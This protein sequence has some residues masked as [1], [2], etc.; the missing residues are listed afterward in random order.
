MARITRPVI[1][2]RIRGN[3]GSLEARVWQQWLDEAAQLV[4][5]FDVEDNDDPFAYNETASVSLLCSAAARIGCLPLAEFTV[6]KKGVKD[7]RRRSNGRA[8]FWMRET[9]RDWAFEF[10]QI[11]Y[12]SITLGRIRKTMRAA[13]ECAKKLLRYGPEHMISGLVVPLYYTD[14]REKARE[15]LETFKDECSFAWHLLSTDDGP[16]TFLFFNQISQ[17]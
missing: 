4:S 15:K 10:K 5:R 12:G 14:A 2:T 8:D 3:A 6:R 1:A 9:G 13:D 17:P 16:E 11:T 7:S